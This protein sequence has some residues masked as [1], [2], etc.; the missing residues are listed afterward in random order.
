MIFLIFRE[1]IPDWVLGSKRW[2]AKCRIGSKTGNPKKPTDE[3]DAVKERFLADPLT[4]N[5]IGNFQQ[6]SVKE[7]IQL[8]HCPNMSALPEALQIHDSSLLVTSTQSPMPLLLRDDA[9]PSSPL[10]AV[11]L[12]P[13]DGMSCTEKKAYIKR[14]LRN[15]GAEL[16]PGMRAHNEL[17]RLQ[18]EWAFV[19]SA[20]PVTVVLQQRK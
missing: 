18:S 16:F 8:L 5:Y 10:A 20:C 6:P 13:T 1:M 15:P 9:T 2:Q 12:S 17:E 7:L 3:Y 19:A 4:N 14:L 11:S